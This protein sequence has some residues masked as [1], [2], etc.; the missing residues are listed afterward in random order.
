MAKYHFIQSK[1]CAFNGPVVASTGSHDL[2]RPSVRQ[3]TD[4]E[5]VKFQITLTLF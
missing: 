5:L 3:S 2:K 1:N 4:Y